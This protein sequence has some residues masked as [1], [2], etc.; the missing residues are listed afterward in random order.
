GR[1]GGAFVFVRGEYRRVIWAVVRGRSAAPVT[2][3][4]SPVVSPDGRRIVFETQAGLAVVNRD[5]SGRKLVVRGAWDAAWSPDGRRIAFVSSNVNDEANVFTI[6]SD[7]SN[8][9]RLTRRAGD[10][11]SSPAWSPDGSRI[12]FAGDQ[13]L[14]IVVVKSR[15]AERLTHDAPSNW[16]GVTMSVAWS[17]DG[18]RLAFTK[19]YD[20]GIFLIS[21]AGTHEQRLTDTTSE[22]QDLTWTPDG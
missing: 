1:D 6:D 5:G 10:N 4:Y 21:A 11:Y 20:S 13:A 16:H 12:A 7:G 17:P 14:R 3:G 22:E 18:R 9:T 15:I 19:G 8:R 2:A